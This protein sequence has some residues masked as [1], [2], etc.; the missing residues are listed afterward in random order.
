MGISGLFGFGIL[1]SFIPTKAQLVGLAAWQIGLILGGGAVIFSLMS[2]TIGA[3]S[4]RYGRRVLVIVSQ[5][6]IVLAG[7]GFVFSDG[8]LG[9]A[10]FYGL[11]CAA[12]A[13]P[14]LLCF[15]YAAEIF[16][17][18]YLGTSMGAFDSVMDLS[19]FFGPLLAVLAY[20]TTLQ[21]A[22]VFLI[23][24]APALLGLVAMPLW[25]PRSPARVNVGQV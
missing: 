9:L 6:G 4:D 14:Y 7:I 17:Q 13:I 2:Y 22:P 5:L 15:V 8:V 24:V 23:A 21:L 11:F 3:W 18:K 19:L 20:K 12:E 16:D 10:L 1:Y 25:L